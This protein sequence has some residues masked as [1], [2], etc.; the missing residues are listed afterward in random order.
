MVYFKNKTPWGCATD[1][2]ALLK[3]MSK[4]TFSRLLPFSHSDRISE[5]PASGNRRRWSRLCVI[6]P[7]NRWGED[8]DLPLYQRFEVSHA[9]WKPVCWSRQVRVQ[10]LRL[11][12]MLKISRL[13]F[14]HRI[15]LLNCFGRSYWDFSWNEF[16]S[17]IIHKGCS[18]I[19]ADIPIAVE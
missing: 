8:S 10:P 16:P 7:Q 4:F 12:G 13:Y 11:A 1:S 14:T 18:W 6:V 15:F 5:Q 9:G 2:R 19:H 3:L 17:S